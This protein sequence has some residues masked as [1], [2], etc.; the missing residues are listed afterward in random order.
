MMG[1]P[2]SLLLCVL[3]V[4]LAL[5]P[6]LVVGY[7]L[8]GLGGD[9]LFPGIFAGLMIGALVILATDLLLLVGALAVADVVRY[10]GGKG[11]ERSESSLDGDADRDRIL[12]ERDG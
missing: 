7:L 4:V 12:A 2:V 6:V 9:R 3:V 10:G 8:S 1:R 5:M 11:A